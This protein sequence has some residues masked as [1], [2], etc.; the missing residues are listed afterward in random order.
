VDAQKEGH[1]RLS[2]LADQGL[3]QKNRLLT[4]GGVTDQEEAD[5]EDLFKVG[6]YLRL[7]NRTFGQEVSPSD[8]QGKDPIVRRLARFEG[9]PRFDHGAPADELLRHRDEI[10][11]QLSEKTLR[12]FEALFDAINDTMAT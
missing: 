11:P 1:Q 9:E 7:Y 5:I 10:L 4:I 12:R 3:L 2:H 8:L 6:D